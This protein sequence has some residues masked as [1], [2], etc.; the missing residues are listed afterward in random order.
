MVVVALA[1]PLALALMTSPWVALASATAALAVRPLRVV[2]GGALG[3]GLIPALKLTGVLLLV[4]GLVLG[5]LL[6]LA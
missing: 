5:L 2:L 1:V 6:G 4:Y 3:P